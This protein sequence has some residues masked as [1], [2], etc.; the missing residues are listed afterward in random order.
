MLEI[1]ASIWHAY[2]I[3]ID[4]N[5]SIRRLESQPEDQEMNSHHFQIMDLKK[6]LMHQDKSIDK[7][8]RR[9][10]YLSS[11]LESQSLQQVVN[12]KK[13]SKSLPGFGKEHVQYQRGGISW[14]PQEQQLDEEK[15]CPSSMRSS[16]AQVICKL[17]AE[18]E[19]LK[20][21]L[22]SANIELKKRFERKQD[23]DQKPWDPVLRA[24]DEQAI[25]AVA[26]EN[27]E[28]KSRLKSE[29]SVG[30]T[31]QFMDED[32]IK[33]RQTSP[34][35]KERKSSQKKQNQQRMT[36]QISP[37]K[38]QRTPFTDELNA[39]LNQNT[40]NIKSMKQ[41]MDED[42]IKRRQTSPVNKRRKSSKK[43]QNQQR[44]T[45]PISPSFRQ[46]KKLK[47][48]RAPLDDEFVYA[49]L[50]KM[51]AHSQNQ[52][53]ELNGLKEENKRLSAQAPSTISVKYED[54]PECI[55]K[56]KRTLVVLYRFVCNLRSRHKS[57][58]D[59]IDFKLRD[60]QNIISR[61]LRQSQYKLSMIKKGINKNVTM[62]NVDEFG[63]QYASL[64]KILHQ[65]IHKV[66]KITKADSKCDAWAALV[67]PSED[68]TA[69]TNSN[70]LDW[71]VI[72]DGVLKLS[73]DEVDFLK[74]LSC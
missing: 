29:T 44:M 18:N 31:K 6:Q 47:Q 34:V 16:N 65:Q 39:T 23:E 74:K 15:E 51:R 68:S 66:Q 36:M 37:S 33:R 7:Y 38:S 22:Q 71:N 63:Y 57:F 73:V 55:E 25:V 67:T 58:R 10:T 5:S 70:D 14:D 54:E 4:I 8:K 35:N 59:A 2:A 27:M 40:A 32:H 48:G 62:R 24:S 13:R 72:D 52:K 64:I 17:T 21:K 28:L 9:C 60:I 69:V 20:S 3:K 56:L 43:K 61:E 30:S 53:V 26:E 41:F 11:Q 50:V 42:H 19:E 46:P 45:M 49:Q 12:A 1:V